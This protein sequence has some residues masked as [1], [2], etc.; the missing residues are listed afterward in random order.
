WLD[1]S[2]QRYRVTSVGLAGTESFNGFLEPRDLVLL[3]PSYEPLLALGTLVHEWQHL[4]H[5][6]LRDSAAVFPVAGG[7]VRLTQLNPFLAEGLAEWAA[8]QILLPV[9]ERYPL[10]RFGEAEKRL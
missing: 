3:D 10:L 7:P 9:S 2:G 8:E 4:L 1:L 5:E 6:H